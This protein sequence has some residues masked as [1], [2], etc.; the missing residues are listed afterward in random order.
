MIRFPSPRSRLSPFIALA[1][2][3]GSVLALGA[4]AASLQ[5]SPVSISLRA[6]QAAGGINLQNLGERPVYGQVRVF[7][8]D[9]RNGEDVLTPTDELVASPPIIEVGAKGSQTIRLVRKGGAAAGAAPGNPERTYRLLIDEIPRE[10]EQASGVA[11]RLQYSVPVFVAPVDE[12]AAPNLAWSVL[13]K[14]NAWVLRVRNSGAL[15][16]Q[17]GAASLVDGAGKETEI[18]KGLLG[19]ALAGREREWRLPVEPSVRL[20]APLTVRANVNA[21]PSSAAASVAAES[22]GGK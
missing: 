1:A 7:A 5:I 6:N 2:L 3:V 8:W 10:D 4:Q 17:V 19:Y 13:R 11:I 14:D 21:R 16:A 20:G 9:Q 22:A 12:A 18:S 15:H